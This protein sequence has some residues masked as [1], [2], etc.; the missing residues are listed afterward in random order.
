VLPTPGRRSLSPFLPRRTTGFAAHQLGQALAD[1]QAQAGAAV[2]AGGEPSACSKGTNSRA[3][4]R[5]D[6]DAGVLHL[7]AQPQAVAVGLQHLGTQ[8]DAA[9]RG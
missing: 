7:E 4:C 3:C 8:G 5:R 2:A 6:A 1:R 9:L